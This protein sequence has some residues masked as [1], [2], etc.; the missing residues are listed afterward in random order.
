MVEAYLMITM[1]LE[2][3]PVVFLIGVL[4]LTFFSS[5]KVERYQL[6]AIRD[7]MLIIISVPLW[8]VGMLLGFGII[9]ARVPFRIMEIRALLKGK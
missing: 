2:I 9:I 1:C 4:L 8:P 7:L 6:E 5:K 3:F